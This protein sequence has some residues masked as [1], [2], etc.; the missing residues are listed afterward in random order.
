MMLVPLVSSNGKY[1]LL[2][3]VRNALLHNAQ[4]QEADDLAKQDALP[5]AP[6]RISLRRALTRRTRRRARRYRHVF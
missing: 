5:G 3:H 4:S 2:I 6:D 1:P